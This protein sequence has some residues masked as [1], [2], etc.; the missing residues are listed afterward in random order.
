MS[1]SSF[2][3]LVGQNSKRA[4][5][6]ADGSQKGWIESV[7]ADAYPKLDEMLK[8]VDTQDPVK[9]CIPGITD[10]TT[11]SFRFPKSLDDFGMRN[12]LA[13][14]YGDLYANYAN[15]WS[16]D[17][18]EIVREQADIFEQ[19]W[20]S[21]P[22]E[23]GCYLY[24]MVSEDSGEERVVYVGKQF[25][26]SKSGSLRKRYLHHVKYNPNEKT[27]NW[28]GD[29][30][31]KPS[32]GAGYLGIRVKS[33]ELRRRGVS[34]VYWVD[35]LPALIE[36]MGSDDY[37]ILQGSIRSIEDYFITKKMQS[38][39]AACDSQYSGDPINEK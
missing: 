7:P 8:G 18:P 38:I 11:C 23:Y 35:F 21:F 20:E 33:A 15:N 3:K 1:R 9:A 37:Q 4:L 36:K 13:E 2:N 10:F 17:R 30:I 5:L 19:V 34:K 31:N 16:K 27:D 26:K 29:C 24:F 32:V 39:S 22:A 14:S 25:A 28:I 12:W 6:F